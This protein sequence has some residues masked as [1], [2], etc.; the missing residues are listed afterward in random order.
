M[1]DGADADKPAPPHPDVAAPCAGS[2]KP[3]RGSLLRRPAS[4][5]PTGRWRRRPRQPP[6]S[7]RAQGA[8]PAR[9]GGAGGSGL[10]TAHPNHLG[11]E[12][13]TAALGPAAPLPAPG[14]SQARCRRRGAARRTCN[15]APRHGRPRA[16]RAGASTACRRRHGPAAIAARGQNTLARPGA[17]GPGV[18]CFRQRACQPAA[19]EPTPRQSHVAGAQWRRGAAGRTRSRVAARARSPI[20]TWCPPRR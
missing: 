1:N 13:A 20:P 19:A 10:A 16:R 18:A 8:T 17:A 14:R 7:G 9:G 15:R 2:P 12:P 6:R 4:K 11:P 3:R 5:P